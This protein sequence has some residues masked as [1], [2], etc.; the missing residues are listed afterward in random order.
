MWL[1][2]HFLHC[3]TR[4]R[5]NDPFSKKPFPCRLWSAYPSKSNMK[6]INQIG[7][8]VNAEREQA[9]RFSDQLL[10]VAQSNG[11]TVFIETEQ[12]TNGWGDQEVDMVLAIGG[13]GTMLRAV[14]KAYQSQVPVLGFNLGTVGFLTEAAPDQMEVVLQRIATA[15]FQ[16]EQRM[17]LS[18]RLNGGATA[19]GVN[20]VVIEKIESQHLVHLDLRVD[21]CQVVDYR[22]DGL[23]VATSTGSTAYSFSAGGPLIDPSVEALV[24]TP[25][26]PHSLFNRTI[27][28]RPD[29]VLTAQ[30]QAYRSVRVTLDGQVLG[31][32]DA[33][34]SVEIFRASHP[35]EFVGFSP[36]AFPARIRDRLGL[37]SANVGL[38][39]SS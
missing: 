1:P 7:I 19:T 30:V 21:G 4:F 32:L 6:T 10:K 3:L 12:A 27:L 9:L 33:G 24:V 11:L 14:Q 35:V 37:M 20:D 15:D 39:D 22:A 17:A 34:D 25:V 16:V 5:E 23:I 13:D 18:A 8:I 36:R 28:F 26:A 29:S 31:T 38:R 2:S